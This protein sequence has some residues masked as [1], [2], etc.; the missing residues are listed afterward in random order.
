MVQEFKEAEMY[1]SR[2]VIIILCL[3]G[4]CATSSSSFNDA[5]Q[6]ND[7]GAYSKFLQD[8]PNS[9]EAEEAK[10]LYQLSQES[11]VYKNAI[12]KNSVASLSRYIKLFPEGKHFEEINKRWEIRFYEEAVVDKESGNI[13]PMKKLLDSFPNGKYAKD[14]QFM[15]E[16]FYF[17]LAYETYTAEAFQTFIKNYPESDYR[18]DAESA[19]YAVRA[20]KNK[21]SFSKFMKESIAFFKKQLITKFYY[22]V[23]YEQQGDAWLLNEL[24]HDDQLVDLSNRL[25]YIQIYLESDCNLIEDHKSLIFVPTEEEALDYL[26]TPIDQFDDDECR[27]K[28][29]IKAR[30]GEVAFPI[31]KITLK[32]KISAT[33]FLINYQQIVNEE[34]IQR[35]G[36]IKTNTIR[37]HRLG[38]V[39][40][41]TWLVVKG[42]HDII[43]SQGSSGSMYIF[44]EIGQ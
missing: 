17:E 2:A 9:P 29:A 34:S 1:K 10:K 20:V 19:I 18:V 40:L 5:K 3:I 39:N 33:D 24:D 4:G 27:K 6:I 31:E 14:A 11:E 28:I 13:E 44:G 36:I 25:T 43:T 23:D 21:K 35:K 22:Q 32:R 37:L 30:N 42:A 41:R 16:E 7:S 8:Y 26:H 38:D 12:S 15:I